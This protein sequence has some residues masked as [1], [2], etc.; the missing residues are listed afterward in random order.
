M[1]MVKQ[2]DEPQ[3]NL[4]AN[5]LRPHPDYIFAYVSYSLV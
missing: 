2:S 4:G 1:I 5:N 3:L